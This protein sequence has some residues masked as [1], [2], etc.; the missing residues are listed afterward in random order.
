MGEIMKITKYPQSCVLIEA[1]GKNILIDPGKYTY[2][3]IDMKPEDWKNIDIL[4]LTH[5]HADHM[6]PEAIKIIAKNN[7]PVILT[8]KPVHDILEKEGIKSEILNPGQERII[9]NIKITGVKSKHGDLPSGNLAPE[10]I[11]FLIDDKIY[12]PGDTVYL[13]EKPYAD[14]VF[15]PICGTVVMDAKEVVRFVKEIKPKLVIPIHYSSP[16]YPATTDEFE[17]EIKKTNLNYKILKNK[18]SIEV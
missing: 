10:V 12:H 16:V 5:E 11:G 2:E 18:E 13:K 15:V 4:L 3:Q 7:N 1:N 17:K 9:E 6:M 14:I 8:N